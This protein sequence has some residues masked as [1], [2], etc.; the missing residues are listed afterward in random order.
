M[1]TKNLFGEL[2]SV[3]SASRVNDP[4]QAITNKIIEAMQQ[5]IIPWQR[6][7]S[8]GNGVGYVSHSTGRSYSFL[9]AMLL[10]IAGKEPGEFITFKQCKEA[11]GHVKKGAKSTTIY[12]WKRLHFVEDKKDENGNTILD[13]N[14]DPEKIEKNPICLKGYQ[15]FALSDTEG[16]NPKYVTSPEDSDDT[17]PDPVKAAEDIVNAYYQEPG[18]PA[19]KVVPSDRA[20][21]SPTS[22]SVTVPERKQYKEIAEYYSTLFHETI[23]STGHK[24]RLDRFKTG[25]AAAF[26]SNDYSREELVAEIGS[27]YLVNRSGIDCQKAFNNSVAYLQGWIRH[28]ADKPREFAT[29]AAQA[30]KAAKYIL[31]E[32]K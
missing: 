4:Y 13:E 29:A 11:G 8:G 25:A 30:E 16:V 31:G 7:W 1:K 28:L 12:F 23:H 2:E 17:A 18:A 20:F 21:Y 5:G 10:M 27:A 24:S 22:D 9:N 19:L 32:S 3:K 26:G 14:G 15:V 6:P